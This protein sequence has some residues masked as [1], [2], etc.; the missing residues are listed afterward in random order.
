MSEAER[1]LNAIHDLERKVGNE[2]R[3]RRAEM[4][5][6]RRRS[7][8]KRLDLDSALFDSFPGNDAVSFLEPAPTKP[9]GIN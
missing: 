7:D 1:L 9:I 6:G 5:S 4:S 8:R 3:S 2:R